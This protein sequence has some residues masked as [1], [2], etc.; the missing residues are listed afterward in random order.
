MLFKP[1]LAEAI[2]R[3]KKT[4][5][6]RLKKPTHRVVLRANCIIAIYQS[7]RLLWRIGNTYAI[8][9]GRGKNAIGRFHL[10]TIRHEPL[11]TITS[12]DARAEGLEY[13][14]PIKPFA[15]LWDDI[16]TTPGTR[17]QDNPHVFVLTFELITK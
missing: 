3:G 8:Q 16:H 2:C 15:R 14:L 6:R 9:P 7:N 10:L 5:T 11:Q 17:W 12:A 13:A 1:Y 4:Q